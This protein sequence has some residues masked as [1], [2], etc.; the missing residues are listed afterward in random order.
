ME[1]ALPSG[2]YHRWPRGAL[3]FEL[4]NYLV[5]KSRRE[6]HMNGK[7]AVTPQVLNLV[8]VIVSCVHTK[9]G[10]VIGVRLDFLLE[11]GDGVRRIAGCGSMVRMSLWSGMMSRFF[12]DTLIHMLDDNERVEADDG[13][14]G[15]APCNVKCP[16]MFPSILSLY[17]MR[18]RQI[19]GEFQI[20]HCAEML[21]RGLQSQA[22]RAKGVPL[23]RKGGLS[24]DENSEFFSAR[25]LN[26]RTPSRWAANQEK[27]S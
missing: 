20:S 14:C 10:V 21:K 12:G 15:E 6:K 3:S 19:G 13:H 26:I 11:L 8:G 9:D 18:S 17:F 24:C 25:D 16:A 4:Y 1:V 22:P 27:D 7:A 23:V 2:R 5:A